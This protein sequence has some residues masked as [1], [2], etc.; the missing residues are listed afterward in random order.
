MATTAE[1]QTKTFEHSSIIKTTV[2]EMMAFHEQENAFGILTP[3]PVF[4]QVHRRDL[5][6]IRDGEIAFT[7]WMGPVPVKWLAEHRP[8]PI[9]TSFVDFQVKGPLKYWEHRHIFEPVEGGVRLTDR[10][11]IAHQDGLQGI[12]TRLIFDGL[13][14]RM[15]FIYRHLRTRLALS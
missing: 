7:M 8:G 13:P 5:N 2:E 9:E 3:P 15:L 1:I 6:S 12:I 4:I 10:I 11:S 14:L